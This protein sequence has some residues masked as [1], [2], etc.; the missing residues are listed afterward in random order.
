MNPIDALNAVTQ[1]PPLFQRLP[2][3]YRQR[4]AEQVPP[5][6]LQAFVEALDS[7]FIAL[8]ERVEGQYDDLF[9][10]SCAPW[11]IP[12]LADLVGTS[13]LKGDPATL[14]ADVARTV[15]H[16]RR[17]GTLGAVESQVHALSGWAV[18][19][20]ELR[21]RLGWHQQLNHLRPDP[22]GPGAHAMR[23]PVRGGTATL[24]SP[25][26]L[27][28]V[29]GPFDPFARSVDLK[30][31]LRRE[32]EG[33]ARAAVN[34]P[35]LAVFLWRLRDFAV[36]VTQPARAEVVVLAPAG[37]GLARF[38]VRFDAHPNGD[39]MRLF[40]RHRYRADDEPPTLADADAVPHPMP[41]A[42]LS[43]GA[44][45]GRP[46]AYLQVRT[47]AGDRASEAA[48][49]LPGLALHLPETP[50]AGRAWRLR[51]ANLCAWEAGLAAPLGRDEL[52][53][54]PDTGRLVFGVGG[55]AAADEAEPLAAG[56][57]LTA[58]HGFS[59][60]VGA[61]P[62][63]RTAAPLEPGTVVR[64]VHRADG[65]GVLA[66][67]LVDLA[68]LGV[69]L[70]V[71]I[72]DSLTHD[73]DP[74]VL[75]LSAPLTIRA[76]DGQCPTLRLAR[77]LRLRPVSI[78][79]GTAPLQTRLDVALQG[80]YLTRSAAFP[81]GAALIEQA[82]LNRLAIA[83]CTLDPGGARL[84]DGS[85]T[86]GRGPLW[87]A[88]TLGADYG[89]SDP[90]ELQD[91]SQ[92]PV[93]HLS[94]CV[95]GALAV[96]RGYAL[97]L[98][99]SIVD[100]GAGV[101]AQTPLP[102][103]VGVEA[104]DGPGWG[105]PL[106]FSGLTVFGR[107]RVE[108]ANGSGGIFVHA[109]QVHDNQ[110]ASCVRFSWFSGVDDRLPEHLGCL[111]GTGGTGGPGGDP[112]ARLLFSDERFGEPGYAQLAWAGD[113][114]LREAG[115]QDDEMGAFGFLL[116]THRWKNIG[117]RLREFMPVGMRALRVPVT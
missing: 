90:A 85:A 71:E 73:W 104:G 28:F 42:R 13:H 52:V 50:F 25:A 106:S 102:L 66:D 53:V 48:G 114:R 11:V 12:Y 96:P 99:D 94:R 4:D 80:L 8:R 68:T 89:L 40:N 69:P 111:F 115:P 20:V 92:L 105:A 39:P 1:A 27:S 45:A 72:A 51:G 44:P 15:Y 34:L 43:S 6:Q 93:L 87:P 97:A 91:F 117:I 26:W 57:R 74:G 63:A 41:A 98:T 10:E 76:L 82:A 61:Q 88:L 112:P 83:D 110:A 16:R 17:K 47:Y 77:P 54:D 103:A 33:P 7:V 5:G 38:A 2:E 36:P 107:T 9:I 116:N 108:T 19:A 55:A 95:C 100:A 62:V 70:V 18:H 67:A 78:G 58:T 64:R 31:P 81:A 22:L 59:G 84:L 56:L 37:P 79:G 113:R 29:D 3:L 65:A 30:P 46:H 60:P 32:G 35:N 86:G 21:D 23:D 49:D 24:R 14:R 109:L 101:A 75:A